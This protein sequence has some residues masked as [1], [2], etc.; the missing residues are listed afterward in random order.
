VK[1]NGQEYKSL[2][3]I[4]YKLLQ[5]SQWHVTVAFEVLKACCTPTG[6]RASGKMAQDLEDSS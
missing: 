6:Y 5:A 1:S 2:E 3:N 4:S